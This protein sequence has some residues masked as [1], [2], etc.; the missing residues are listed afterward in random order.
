MTR[1]RL[2]FLQW[3]ALFGGALAFTGNEVFGYGLTEAACNQAATHWGGI[4]MPPWQILTTALTAGTTVLA[5]IAALVV[6]LALKDVDKDAP[7]P[8][9]RLRFFAMA[10]ILGNV[11]FCGACLMQGVGAIVHSPCGQS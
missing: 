11:L 5:G 2:E 9:G 4:S 6:F 8:N 10:A 1:L 3:F 7:G